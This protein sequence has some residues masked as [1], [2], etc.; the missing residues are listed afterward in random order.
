MSAINYT[1]KIPNNVNLAEDRTLQR[2][3]E[4]WQPDFVGWWNE[5]GPE[6]THDSAVDH[7]EAPQQQRDA[8]HQ[9]EQD[10]AAGTSSFS[11]RNLETVDRVR[12]GRVRS[13]SLP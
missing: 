7:V 13:A 6:G 4:Q 12:R 11:S 1:E 8:T 2:A 5:V 3:L 9:V 10:H